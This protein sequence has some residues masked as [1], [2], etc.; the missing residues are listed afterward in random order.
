[1]KRQF[2]VKLISPAGEDHYLLINQ[3]FNQSWY[4]VGKAIRKAKLPLY[5]LNRTE[6]KYFLKSDDESKIAL[7]FRQEI[8]ALKSA[9]NIKK[10]PLIQISLKESE[11][12]VSVRI[13]PDAEAEFD[14]VFSEFLLKNIQKNIQ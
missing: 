6:G 14:P 8:A 2:D 9:Y 12:G 10:F 7:V 5:D 13:N 3:D 4:L 11:E 1:M